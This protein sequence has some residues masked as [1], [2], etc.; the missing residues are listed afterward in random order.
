MMHDKCI[1]LS[2]EST[3]LRQ[4]RALRGVGVATR[5]EGPLQDRPG[6]KIAAPTV[7]WDYALPLSRFFIREHLVGGL[8]L[9]I[10]SLRERRLNFLFS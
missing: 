5:A 9:P 2:R 3:V 4:Q 8:P 10:I 7:R 1:P 6:G